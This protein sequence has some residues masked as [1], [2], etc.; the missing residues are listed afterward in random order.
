MNRKT[1]NIII[2]A[3]LLLFFGGFATLTLLSADYGKPAM[4]EKA[5]VSIDYSSGHFFIREQDVED[6]IDEYFRDVAVVNA[7][8]LKRLEAFL[9]RLPHVKNA[10]AYIDSRGVLHVSIVQ[11]SPKARIVSNS[12]G[13]YYVDEARLKFPVSPYYTAKVPVITGAVAENCRSVEAVSS[14][15]LMRALNVIDIAEQDAFWSAQLAEVHIAEDGLS[16]IPRMGN[17]VIIL[18]DDTALE[19]KFKRLHLF[20]NNVLNGMG[21][22]AYSVLDLRYKNQI[23]CK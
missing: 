4:S 15:S 21:W 1:R 17:H 8:Q 6:K 11:R 23:V 2:K 10:N 18:G 13:N 9:L 12:G 5:I 22:K 19:D 16:L 3:L 20:Y 7:E 14:L